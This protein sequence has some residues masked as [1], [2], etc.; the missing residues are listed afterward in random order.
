MCADHTESWGQ[1]QR[2]N[3]LPSAVTSRYL[4]RFVPQAIWHHNASYKRGDI[5]AWIVVDCYVL[6]FWALTFVITILDVRFCLTWL[7]SPPYL[8]IRMATARS[9]YTEVKKVPIP[10]LNSL[11]ST[12]L[13]A[14]CPFKESDRV[15]NA[16]SLV[17]PC[18]NVA[19]LQLNKQAGTDIRE[20]GNK[21]NKIPWQQV[22]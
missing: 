7:D 1:I 4:S 17:I 9:I 15:T 19:L 6:C 20:V 11:N 18:I 3:N 13:K 2:Y 5:S 8:T 22:I 14:V 16:C 12:Q 21:F 10:F